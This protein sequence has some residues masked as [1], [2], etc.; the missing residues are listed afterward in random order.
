MYRYNQFPFFK[1]TVNTLCLLFC[2]RMWPEKPDRPYSPLRLWLVLM[3][4]F[5]II[6]SKIAW[7]YGPGKLLFDFTMRVRKDLLVYVGRGV[8]RIESIPI[9]FAL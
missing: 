8:F 6:V 4:F 5:N 1:L 3:V 7:S 2:A 9:C